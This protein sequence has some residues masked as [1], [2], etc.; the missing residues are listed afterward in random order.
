MTKH[1]RLSVLTAMKESG[2]VPIFNH[3]DPEICK[4]VIRACYDGGA[5]VFEFTNRGQSALDVFRQIVGDV[6]REMGDLIIG[7]GSIIDAPTAALFIQTG[8][9]FVVSP[10]L[11][12]EVIKLCNRHKI[13]VIPGCGSVSEIS[14]AEELGVE[15]IKIFPA[16]QVGGPAFVKAVLAPMPWVSMMPTGGVTTD[17][18]NLR[19]WFEAGVACV[20]IGSNLMVMETDGTYDFV[21]IIQKTKQ[22]IDWIANFRGTQ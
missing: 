20:G 3:D 1:S 9:Q 6:R 4:N 5:K 16:L 21:G 10:I 2:L 7:V 22:T 18:D 19:A 8:A 17:E 13:A 11:N 14:L 15:I 12:P